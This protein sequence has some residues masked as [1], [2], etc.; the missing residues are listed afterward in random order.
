M[1]LSWI[2]AA[3]ALIACTSQTESSPQPARHLQIT[4]TSFRASSGEA[5]AWRGISAFRLTELVA[6]R[7]REEATAFLDWAASRGLTVV[8]V[9][10]MAS[11]LFTL[12]PEEGVRALPELLEMAAAR[13]LHV[14]IVALADTAALGL[15]SIDI[16]AHVKAVGAIAGRYPNALLE[17]A[18]E[19]S[20]PTQ[21]RTIH[22]PRELRRLASLVPA[23]V[24]VSLGS[25]EE[26]DAFAAGEYATFHFPRPHGSTGWGHVLALARG[27]A[28]VT[29]WNKPVVSDEPIGAAPVA[30]AGRRDSDPDRFRA[31]A[32]LSRLAGLGATFHYEQGLHA[33]IPTGQEARCFEAWNE[34]WTLLPSSLE[35]QGTFREAGRPGAAVASFDPKTAEAVFERQVGATAYVL[36]VNATSEPV[37]SWSAGWRRTSVKRLGG[38]WLLTGNRK[39]D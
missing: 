16:G 31:A 6:H 34:A 20:H 27:A 14:E 1:R 24:P 39:A 17:I 13:G 10:T 28:L 3:V 8:R 15:D 2:L 19:P 4:G 21:A 35:Q 18:N 36:V 7:R 22:D 12:A 11:H 23:P 33:K 5:F 37:V 30:I 26:N 38:A 29:A 32:L 9:L 25:A